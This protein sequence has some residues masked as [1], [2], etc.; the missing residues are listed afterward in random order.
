MCSQITKNHKF[1]GQ[2]FAGFGP[3]YYRSE[4]RFDND[5]VLTGSS[6]AGTFGLG[7]DYFTTNGFSFG[8]ETSVTLGSISRID[9]NNGMRI[10]EVVLDN[11]ENITHVNLSLVIGYQGN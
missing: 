11:N 7:L 9:V 4:I 8:L 1:L 2:A 10:K 6:L 5:Y 3:L